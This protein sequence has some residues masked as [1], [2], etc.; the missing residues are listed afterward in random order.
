VS[1]APPGDTRSLLDH[2]LLPVANEDDAERTAAV[3]L[4]HIAAAGGRVSLVY[5]LEKAGG[6]LDK[7]PV[8]Q[9]EELAEAAFAAF[10]E[11]AREA[12]VPVESEVRYDTDVVDAIFEAAEEADATAIVFR[13]RGGRSVFDLLTGDVRDRIVTESRRPV[14]VLPNVEGSDGDDG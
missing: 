4:P 11:A 2:P 14:V 13:P 1:E 6:A 10:R 7:A 12:G 8:E 3:A 9:R 5:V